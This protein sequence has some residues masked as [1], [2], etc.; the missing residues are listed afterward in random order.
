MNGQKAVTTNGIFE[1]PKFE[2]KGRPIDPAKKA[3]ELAQ[4]AKNVK[5]AVTDTPVLRK[6]VTSLFKFSKKDI[7][8]LIPK[9]NLDID[10][11]IGIS[12]PKVKL[13]S[14]PQFGNF[15]SLLPEV[16]K[17]KFPKPS[18]P[19]LDLGINLNLDISIPVPSFPNINLDNLLSIGSNILGDFNTRLAGAN[20][21]EVRMLPTEELN[22]G[23][24]IDVKFKSGTGE[25]ELI[26]GVSHL[27]VEESIESLYRTGKMVIEERRG[28]TE[29]TNITNTFDNESVVVRFQNRFEQESDFREISFGLFDMQDEPENNRTIFKLKE[30]PFFSNYHKQSISKSYTS[31]PAD[32]IIKDIL[33]T[34]VTKGGITGPGDLEPVLPIYPCPN[35]NPISNIEYLQP[36]SNDGPIKVFNISNKTETTTIVAPLKKMMEG[37]LYKQELDIFPSPTNLTKDGFKLNEWVLYGP[38]NERIANSSLRGESVISFSHN[39]N[40]KASNYSNNN[41]EANYGK[42]QKGETRSYAETMTGDYKEGVESN[43]SNTGKFTPQNKDTFASKSGKTIIDYDDKVVARAKMKSRFR[44]DYYDNLMLKIVLPGLSQ[45]N[46]GQIFDIVLPNYIDRE[47][48][49]TLISGKWMLHTMKHV[50][51]RSDGGPVRGRV[52][53]GVTSTKLGYNIECF[54]FRSG[55]ELPQ[56]HRKATPVLPGLESN[57]AQNQFNDDGF[58]EA[59]GTGLA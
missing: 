37:K 14:P 25:G 40:K 38:K 34:Y 31:L 26:E 8:K 28:F 43:P 41:G 52:K 45:I 17:F 39:S 24:F 51:T 9:V 16:P 53:E 2:L 35:T 36:R 55:Y 7:L 22:Q 11:D 18:F 13:P 5:G 50:V 29:N 1:R 58:N 27:E 56:E 10:I 21:K 15:G 19:N 23:G 48:K 12:F 47:D 20:A 57:E 4:A 3:A 32:K 42:G 46:V 30:E 59:Q 33:A 44:E 49:N 54:F 6:R